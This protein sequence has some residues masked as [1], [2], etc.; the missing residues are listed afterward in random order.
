[1]NKRDSLT[2]LQTRKV[3]LLT[4]MSQG[5]AHA[6]KCYKL[7]KKYQTQYPEEYAEYIAANEEYQ[8]IEQQI[9]EL[10][11]QLSTEEPEMLPMR[12]EE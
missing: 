9:A 3:E 10:E 12:E 6:A 4:I 2:R 11:F 8:T 5:D 1:M 7:G